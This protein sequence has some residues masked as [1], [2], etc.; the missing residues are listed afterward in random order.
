MLV[1]GKYPIRGALGVRGAIT[2][3]ALKRACMRHTASKGGK[4]MKD[5]KHW[6]IAGLVTS[7]I[8]AGV[9][10]GLIIG[11]AIWGGA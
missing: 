7:A 3:P 10:L 1:G 6:D 11:K 2:Y 4:R 8:A 5:F 9:T